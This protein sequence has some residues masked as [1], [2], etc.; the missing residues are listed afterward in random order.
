MRPATFLDA[1]GWLAM[2][3]RRYVLRQANI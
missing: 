3:T 1:E 2:M